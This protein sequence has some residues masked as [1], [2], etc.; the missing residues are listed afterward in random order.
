[1]DRPSREAMDRLLEREHELRVIAE[2][3]CAAAA[4]AGAVVALEGEAGIGKSA[5]LADAVRRGR[6]AGMRILS[7]RAGEIEQQFG[8][9]VVRQL[10]DAPLEAMAQPD[11]ERALCGAAG[12]AT[13]A[14]SVEDSRRGPVLDPASVLHGLYWLSA[15]LAAEQPLL[16]VID[17]A[18]W[19]DGASIAFLSYLARRVQ[20]LALLVIYVTRIGEGSS[21]SLPASTE[22][23]LVG[24]V[25]R[26][27]MLSVHATAEF[28]GRVLGSDCSD[29]FAHACHV[30]TGGN[31]FLLQELLRALR[32]DGTTPDEHNAARVAQM[33]P[34]T[35]GRAILARLRRL[36]DSATA[37]AFATAVLG[38][39]AELRHAA[40]LARLDPDEAG[41][42]ADALTSVAILREGRPLEFIHPIV[43]TTV[44]T[45]IPAARRAA[46]HK[47][48]ALLLE[49]EGVVPAE[50]APHLMATEPS[51]DSHVVH[52]L[53]AAPRTCGHAGPSWRLARTSSGRSPSR[54]GRR[55]ARG[56][57]TSWARP[58]SPPVC[59]GRSITSARRSTAIWTCGRRCRQ[60]SISSR[61]SGWRAVT[62]GWRCSMRRSRGSPR[63]AT[64]RPPWSSRGSTCARR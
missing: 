47:R 11:R 39:S 31:P 9:G 5:L 3:V 27:S 36:G 62:R 30:A 20:G 33:A 45:E 38:K 44:Y 6:H 15:N 64:P 58:S 1:M 17:D 54:R 26:P 42:A 18:H 63:R 12:L 56:C 22:P 46:D 14:L 55:N 34:G 25:L 35:V 21:D 32:A 24:G 4:G 40:T 19:A 61:R 59:T 2:A 16:I 51:A 13:S 10:F 52:C 8:Y 41:V 43:R 50:F 23:G 53:R 29:A 7:A 37:L 57:C 60:G 48:A 49:R 28:V